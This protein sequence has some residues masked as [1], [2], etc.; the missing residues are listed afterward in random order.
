MLRIAIAGRRRP[1]SFLAPHT[2]CYAIVHP[3]VHSPCYM[4]AATST[5]DYGDYD[6]C[7]GDIDDYDFVAE[8]Q[9]S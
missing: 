8:A 3:Y 2:L 6:D 5:M 4:L 9:A 7:G 1:L